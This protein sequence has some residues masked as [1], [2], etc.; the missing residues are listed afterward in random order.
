MYSSLSRR[1]RER[2]LPLAQ[3]ATWHRLPELLM[4][5]FFS[6]VGLAV[7][8]VA[9]VAVN[10]TARAAANEPPLP[11]DGRNDRSPTMPPWTAERMLSFHAPFSLN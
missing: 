10:Q 5:R 7:L 6:L 1:P 9:A 8:V 4:V 11:N 3:G 2:V